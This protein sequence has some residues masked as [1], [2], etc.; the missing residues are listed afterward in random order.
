MAF[1]VHKYNK[2]KHTNYIIYT[3]GSRIKRPKRNRT[4]KVYNG[5]P[6]RDDRRYWKH[7]AKTSSQKKKRPFEDIGYNNKAYSIGI[8]TGFVKRKH[9][10]KQRINQ[11]SGNNFK[12]L[13]QNASGR[14]KEMKRTRQY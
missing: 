2:K 8:N 1:K 6:Q 12:D 9:R 14:D 5:G 4:L 13:C 7:V 11:Y 10:Y 3:K